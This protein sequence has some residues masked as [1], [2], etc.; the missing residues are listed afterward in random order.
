[1]LLGT[2]LSNAYNYD[3]PMK[4]TEAV[5]PPT[6]VQ[7][8]D[9]VPREPTINQL[10]QDQKLY[11]LSN[12]LQ[13]QKEMFE[14]AKASSPG[15]LDKL[16]SKKRDI[17]KL[18][19]VAFVNLLALSTHFVLQHYITLHMESAMYSPNKEFFARILY[20]ITVLFAL[21][22]IRVFNK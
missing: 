1:M 21:W 2:D 9:D 11:M 7:Q 12:E 14:S 3:S 17:G 22:N 18:L 8:K 19:V 15:Y 4:P 16:M 13:K 6:V 20:P 5:R 10:T